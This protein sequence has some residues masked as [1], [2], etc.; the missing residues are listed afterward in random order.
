MGMH[1]S[2]W[3]GQLVAHVLKEQ[4]EIKYQGFTVLI[5]GMIQIL[6]FSTT[7]KKIDI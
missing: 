2:G 1:I 6:M 7:E 5:E 3:H 4:K